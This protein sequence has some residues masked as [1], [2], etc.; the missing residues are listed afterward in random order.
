MVESIEE[1][2]IICQKRDERYD[3]F[4]ENLYRKL[5]IYFTKVFLYTTLS[6]NQITILDI[7]VGIIGCL[8]IA[9]RNYVTSLFVFFMWEI[10][11]RVDGEVAHYRKQSSLS[12]EYLDRSNHLIIEPLLFISFTFSLQ[13]EVNAIYLFIFGFLASTSYN[14][15]KL[16]VFSTHYGVV[17]KYLNS[18]IMLNI[19]LN[20]EKSVGV[21]GIKDSFGGIIFPLYKVFLFITFPPGSILMIY[22]SAFL[23]NLLNPIMLFN[24]SFSYKFICLMSY[25]VLLS[26]IWIFLGIR[27]VTKKEPEKL[28]IKL[29]Y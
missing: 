22:C 19:T 13:L 11:D 2:R 29:F 25:G 16:V 6:A 12:G 28:Y 18:D 10:L 21:E 27:I 1:L 17:E 3:H 15:I 24:L 4:V 7:L 9:K 23:D 14:L 26:L 8:M 20:E 5:S